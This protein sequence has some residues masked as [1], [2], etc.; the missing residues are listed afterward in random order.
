M[1][2]NDFLFVSVSQRMTEEATNENPWPPDT[3]STSVISR[4]AFEV[5]EYE[6][7]MEILH[8]RFLVS[9]VLI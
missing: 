9:Y 8:H 1:F 3:R 7:I 5:D 4:A 6:R 2:D